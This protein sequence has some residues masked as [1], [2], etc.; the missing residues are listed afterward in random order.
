MAGRQSVWHGSDIETVYP[1]GEPIPTESLPVTD[2]LG[3]RRSL[4][5]PRRLASLLKRPSSKADRVCLKTAVA[6]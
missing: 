2:P 1:D 3:A 4:L 5:D 6:K